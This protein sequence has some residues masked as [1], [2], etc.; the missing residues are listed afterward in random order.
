MSRLRN[1]LLAAFSFAAL[2]TGAASAEVVGKVGVD[3]IG[4]DIIVDAVSDPEV[5]GVTCH[6]TYFDRSLI[7]RFKNGNWFED[8]SNN[9]IACRQTGPIEIGN[10]DLSKDGSEVFRQGMSLIWKTLV[11]NRIYDKTNDTLIYLAHS[12]ELT[13]GSAKMSI[14]T[15][16]LYGQS[17]TWKNGKP[18]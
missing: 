13:D 17:V 5:K 9:S 8:P 11:V 7:D 3:W 16:P 18:Q 1:F 10:V 12:R 4:N 14:S 2:S 6:V 15:I